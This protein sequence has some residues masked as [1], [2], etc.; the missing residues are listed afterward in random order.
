MGSVKS[1]LKSEK[2]RQTL[3]SIPDEGLNQVIALYRAKSVPEKVA[4]WEAH[5]LNEFRVAREILGSGFACFQNRKYNQ[6]KRIEPEFDFVLNDIAVRM[7]WNMR[8][9]MYLCRMTPW[10]KEWVEHL[11]LAELQGAGCGGIEVDDPYAGME[12][13]SLKKRKPCCL[14]VLETEIAGYQYYMD[15]WET[16][17]PF[18]LGCALALRRDP[19]NPYDPNAIA[20]LGPLGKK[21]GFVPRGANESLARLMDAGK[22]AFA[23]FQPRN[24]KD[25]RIGVYLEDRLG[26][27]FGPVSE[28]IGSIGSTDE[29]A[30]RP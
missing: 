27:P 20:V 9:M 26:S 17:S 4:Y 7:G 11:A 23:V 16:Q 2:R 1:Y 12:L 5:I 8:E 25:F 10:S 15:A 24:E 28:D 14:L 22:K 29:E 19:F 18:A 21:L 3:L 30:G 13:E 6:W